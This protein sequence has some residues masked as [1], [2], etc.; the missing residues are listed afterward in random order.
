[1]KN[2]SEQHERSSRGKRSRAEILSTATEVLSEM[3]PEAATLRYVARRAGVNIATLM[4][5]FP[6]KELLIAEVL[7]TLDGSELQLVQAWRE[8]L[9]DAQL[10]GLN[11]LKEALTNLAIMIIDRV[12]EDPSRFRLGIFTAL[13]ISKSS[14]D[15]DA[16]EPTK[17]PVTPEKNIVREVLLR[18]MALNT[19]HCDCRE[20]D[21]YIDGF[22]YLSR[23]FT[24]A[25]IQEIAEGAENRDVIIRRFRKIIHRYVNEMLPTDQD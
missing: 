22:T 10:S 5:Y 4:Y 7:R 25:H 23:G 14:P 20:L 11:S 24:I 16:T 9:T 6:S 12:I 2:G 18:A 3:G 13:E 21:D 17:T 19:F 1:M 8:S 15:T